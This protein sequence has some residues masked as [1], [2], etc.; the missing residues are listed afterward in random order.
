MASAHE[1]TIRAAYAA[2]NARDIDAVLA[3]LSNDVQWANG[4]EGGFV[5]GQDAVR[6]YWTGQWTQID[7][8]VE[9]VAIQDEPDGRVNVEVHQVVKDLQG[10]VLNDRTVH[11][12]Y[13]FSDGLVKRM[14]IAG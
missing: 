11:H 3:L 6:D 1:P 8:H 4:M 12:I 5:Q 10:A 14:E 13:T 7:P 9:P 2:F